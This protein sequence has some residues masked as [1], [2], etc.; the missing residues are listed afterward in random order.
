MEPSIE[1]IPVIRRKTQ[2][3]GGNGSLARLTRISKASTEA[4]SNEIIFRKHSVQRYAGEAQE[5]MQR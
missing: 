2:Q 1:V 3:Q 4:C 5:T